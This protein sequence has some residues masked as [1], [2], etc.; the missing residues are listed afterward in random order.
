[1]T[2]ML[3]IDDAASALGMSPHTLRTWV[4]QRRIAFVRLGRAVRIPETEV[5]RLIRVGTVMVERKEQEG[6]T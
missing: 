1:M 2:Q 4:A 6:V 3:K 5:K